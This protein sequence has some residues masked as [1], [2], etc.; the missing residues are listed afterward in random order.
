MGFKDLIGSALGITRQNQ[1]AQG[2]PTG[3][4]ITVVGESFRQDA[5]K[6]AA[7]ANGLQDGVRP[8]DVG[9]PL[10]GVI[11]RE[12]DN[13]HDPKAVKVGLVVN[14]QFEHVGYLPRETATVFSP[15]LRGFEKIGITYLA[16]EAFLIGGSKGLSF[17]VVLNI[18]S[19]KSV[20]AYL[21]ALEEAHAAGSATFRDDVNPRT[22]DDDQTS[23]RF[24]GELDWEYPGWI[25]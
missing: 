20:K 22:F 10:Q 3:H 9:T 12:P 21:S 6:N 2:L 15:I 16:S 24:E 4:D 8:S 5:L 25:K 13:E 7:R 11:F 1:T 14:G 18:A 17:G 23:K 19:K